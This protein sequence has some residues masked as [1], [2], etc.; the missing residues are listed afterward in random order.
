MNAGDWWGTDGR[1]PRHFAEALMQMQGEPEKQKAFV[2]RHVPE[3][4][5]DL[6]RDHYLTALVL[7]GKR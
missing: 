6:V 3:N 1:S 2:E 7:G 4:L 5:R